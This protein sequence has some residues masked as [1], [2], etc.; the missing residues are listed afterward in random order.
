MNIK[1]SGYDLCENSDIYNYLNSPETPLIMTRA[2]LL[3]IGIAATTS[4]ATLTSGVPHG[5][6]A[7]TPVSFQTS[8]AL[9]PPLT[10][11]T[12]YYVAAILSQTTFTV[13]SVLGGTAITMTGAGTGQ[14]SVQNESINSI[15]TTKRAL[16]KNVIRQMILV[17]LKNRIP[18][19]VQAC[20]SY[21][22]MLF[23]KF[24]RGIEYDVNQ[25][26]ESAP[27]NAAG[28]MTSE[29][30]ILNVLVYLNAYPQIRP[31]IFVNFGIPKSGSGGFEN[32]VALAGDLCI[33]TSTWNQIYINKGT[34]INFP[35]W[36]AEYT[37]KDALDNLLN[38]GCG[39]IDD[40]EIGSGGTGYAVNDTGTIS[41]GTLLV[42]YTVTSETGG[43]VSGI[44]LDTTG[45]GY[46]LG[47]A[48]TNHTTGSG[49]GLTVDILS[50][51]QNE[52]LD[53]AV[54]QTVIQMMQDAAFRN[55][56][57][58]ES[59]EAIASNSYQS[60]RMEKLFKAAIFRALPLLEV[61]IDGNGII[62]DHERRLM[63][64]SLAVIG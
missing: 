21:K 12:T 34:D 22:R 41:G 38:A 37:A 3:P 55:R 35:N 56:T 1:F 57:G 32:G 63:D 52:L 36:V 23:N 53:A 47:V 44:S 54:Y 25:V 42:N 40:F 51:K 48:A 18:E 8:N 17:N 27:L 16:A 29:G 30:V 10:A 9:P 14:Q 7:G 49:S 24:V 62:Y 19:I 2:S 59:A 61:D 31:T 11:N 5:L 28:V 60:N 64:T 15:V 46:A 13:A 58:F 45:A 6:L 26:I 39:R 20:L 4:S 50:L 33:D 43:I